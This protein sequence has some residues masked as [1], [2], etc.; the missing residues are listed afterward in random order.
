MRDNFESHLSPE[1]LR[2]YHK[3]KDNTLR[4]LAKRIGKELRLIFDEVVRGGLKP[5]NWIT[6]QA[7]KVRKL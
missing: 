5:I 6:R 1:Q 3:R 7:K 2:E 4:G